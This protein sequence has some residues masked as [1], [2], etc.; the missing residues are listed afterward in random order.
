MAKHTDPANHMVFRTGKAFSRHFDCQPTVENSD[1]DLTYANYK[2]GGL[3]LANG[4]TG[5]YDNWAMN[6]YGFKSLKNDDGW[7]VGGQ[8]ESAE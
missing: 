8:F 7:L 4:A 2:C 6:G 1:K 5:T 3:L